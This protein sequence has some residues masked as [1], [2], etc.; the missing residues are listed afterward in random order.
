MAGVKTV[1]ALGLVAVTVAGCAGEIEMRRVSDK[2]MAD[3]KHWVSGVIVY[4][5]ALFVEISAKTTLIEGG[6]LKGSSADNPPACVPVQS[7]KTVA[8]PDL[9]NPYQIRYDPGLFDSNTFGV[10][11]QTGVLAAVNG[12]ISGA[13]NG[14]P[15]GSGSSG[16]S[17]SLPAIPTPLGIPLA[18]PEEPN[19]SLPAIEQIQLGSTLPACND[20]PV[21]LGYRRL[22]L[23]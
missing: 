7:E 23:P 1:V 14:A 5:P 8:L 6:K 17:L 20:G 15:A 21:V 13:L 2:E 4:Q 11:L 3:T 22:P 16:G 12:N 9:K 18:A 19:T 10:T